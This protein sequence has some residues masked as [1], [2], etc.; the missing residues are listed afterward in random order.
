MEVDFN[1]LA[2]AIEAA[3]ET[4]DLGEDEAPV[5]VTQDLDDF[6]TAEMCPAVSVALANTQHTVRYIVGGMLA[7]SPDELFVDF[8]VTCFEFS[9]QGPKDAN[10]RRNNLVR[11]AVDALR[12]RRSLDGRID[13]L[14]TPNIRFATI[15]AGAGI[16]STAAITVRCVTRG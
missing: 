6:P 11:A 9:A 10:R 8:D 13:W 5:H 1:D 16:Y 3:L 4:I 7:G 12:S 14:E 15:A 2:D